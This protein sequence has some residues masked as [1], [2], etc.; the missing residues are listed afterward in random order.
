MT[1]PP[2]ASAARP[3]WV[4]ILSNRAL[5]RNI[6]KIGLTQVDCLTRMRA[7]ASSHKVPGEW[8]LEFRAAVS[9]VFRAEQAVHRTLDGKRLRWEFFKLPL[10]SAKAELRRA[11]RPWRCANAEVATAAI[12]VGSTFEVP[13]RAAKA[14]AAAVKAVLTR[15]R[16]AAAHKAVLSR[17]AKAKPSGEAEVA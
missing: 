14:R 5:G 3:G 1:S 7:I 2:S 6:L 10:L 16:R 13:D 17:K 11:V 15:R 9:D 12:P 4:Y 8:T